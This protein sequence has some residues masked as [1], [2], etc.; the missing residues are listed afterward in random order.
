MSSCTLKSLFEIELLMILAVKRTDSISDT[1]QNC[2]H[3]PKFNHSNFSKRLLFVTESWGNLGQFLELFI[4]YKT[5][6]KLK[7]KLN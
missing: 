7:S 6:H 5:H 4:I 2:M 1:N 3:E